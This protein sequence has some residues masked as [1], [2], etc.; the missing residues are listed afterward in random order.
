MSSVVNQKTRE[1][2][3][4]VPVI[5]AASAGADAT[6]AELFLRYRHERRTARRR[7]AVMLSLVGGAVAWSIHGTGFE[8]VSFID[9]AVNSV[10]FVVEDMW[11]PDLSAIGPALPGLADTVYMSFFG[12][13]LSVILSLGLGIMGAR[14]TTPHRAVGLA[15]RGTISFI[16]SF[17]DLVFAIILVSAFG[18][19]PVAG[20]LALGIGGVGVLGKLFTESLEE[21]DMT[22]LEGLR[23]AGAGWLQIVGQA[24][25]PQFRPAFLTW[26]LFRLD[27]NIRAAA[28][29]GLV[30]AGGIGYDLNLKFNLFQ[31]REAS[32]IMLMVF[33][34]IILVEWTTMK[35]REKLL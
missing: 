3:N 20:A 5:K 10:Q 6:T 34:L 13:L 14:N 19:G 12:F 24:V 1:I 33:A 30:G 16:R 22:Q 15:C 29:V 25:W 31:F 35:L 26:S 8:L 27:L 9:G 32:T 4:K 18:I 11:P 2:H 17:P 21:I 28:V 7:R 23:A